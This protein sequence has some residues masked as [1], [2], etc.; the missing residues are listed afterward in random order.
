MVCVKGWKAFCFAQGMSA[1]GIEPATF[2]L[3]VEWAQRQWEACGAAPGL[4]LSV[5][6]YLLSSMCRSLAQLF[7]TVPFLT[8]QH[9]RPNTHTHTHQQSRIK[10]RV[11]PVQAARVTKQIVGWPGEEGW[12]IQ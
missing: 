4:F 2:L 5:C 10:V 3:D 8:P 6:F 12:R 7:L 1:A 11:P 9:Q